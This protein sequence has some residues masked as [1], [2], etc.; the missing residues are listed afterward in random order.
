MRQICL[1]FFGQ[2]RSKEAALARESAPS[3]TVPLIV[4]SIFAM[5]LGWVGVAEDFPAIGGLFPDWI[6]QFVIS[7]VEPIEEV[8]PVA[9]APE[10]VHQFEVI[11][12]VTGVILELGG[13]ALGWLV[14]GRK[15]MQPGA[16][17]R[18]WTAMRR[19][20]LGW[21]YQALRDRFYFDELYQW[22]FIKGSILIAAAFAWFDITIIDG[23]VNGVG[24]LGRTLSDANRWFDI[25]VIN[26]TVDLG[27][28][29]QRPGPANSCAAYRRDG[30]SCT[31]LR[32]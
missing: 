3:M 2:P 7:T 23:A 9:I 32:R 18:V 26:G 16:V 22:T 24:W 28:V 1:V 8:E 11:P 6:H 31:C 5:G 4:L 21:L 15:P 14:Y 20:R 29:L 17:D 25:T 27:W 13:L 30:Y 19:A 12:L 10:V